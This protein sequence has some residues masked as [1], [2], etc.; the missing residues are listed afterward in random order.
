M[1]NNIIFL[2][3]ILD[4]IWNVGMAGGWWWGGMEYDFLWFDVMGWWCEVIWGCIKVKG[5]HLIWRDVIGFEDNGY[6]LM[7][8]DFMKLIRMIQIV[9]VVIYNDGCGKPEMRI[10]WLGWEVWNQIVKMYEDQF[11]KISNLCESHQNITESLSIEIWNEG[12]APF[13]NDT[14][15]YEINFWFGMMGW[16]CDL[17]LLYVIW[18]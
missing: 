10:S 17:M 2:E 11:K 1:S 18:C 7:I 13:G 5:K 8:L 9:V 16:W 14:G 6:V 4:G 3:D 12:T 15:W